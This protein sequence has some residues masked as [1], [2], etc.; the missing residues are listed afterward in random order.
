MT[1]L[2]P[3]CSR[4]A[5]AREID[6][7]SG[8]LISEVGERPISITEPGRSRKR[9]PRVRFSGG[10][11][12]MTLASIS[13]APATRRSCE[14]EGCHAC[15]W[16]DSRSWARSMLSVLDSF[17]PRARL[18]TS[19]LDPFELCSF[20]RE[21]SVTGIFPRSTGDVNTAPA[22]AA[23]AKPLSPQSIA[24]AVGRAAL[25]WQTPL[26][27]GRPHAGPDTASH[28]QADG[29][30]PPRLGALARH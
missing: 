30:H 24:R 26:P 12:R 8:K 23:T 15:V 17:I 10:A 2:L 19:L 21:A 3:W 29:D 1:T 5:W 7:T 4:R 6:S 20:G 9:V 27:P 28:R 16:P 25:P 11:M 18:D 13:P 14:A 22:R